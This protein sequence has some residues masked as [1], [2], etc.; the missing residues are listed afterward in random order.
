MPF[1]KKWEKLPQIVI[2]T[3]V[4]GNFPELTYIQTCLAMAYMY[5]YLPQQVPNSKPS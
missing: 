2:E 4:A 5:N 3:L 1:T